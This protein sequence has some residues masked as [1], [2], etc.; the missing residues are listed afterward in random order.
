MLGIRNG[1]INIFRID[2]WNVNIICLYLQIFHVSHPHLFVV[3]TNIHM[4]ILT[5][6]YLHICQGNIQQYIFVN[7]ADLSIIHYGKQNRPMHCFFIPFN[8]VG[9]MT[10]HWA[11]YLDFMVPRYLVGFFPTHLTHWALDKMT[12]IFQTT[13]SNTFSWMKMYKFRLQ[14]HWCLFPGV[15]LTSF[16]HWFR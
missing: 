14:F 16:H 6:I 8:W 2:Y 15:Q 13:H 3:Y 7:C 9:K 5:E 11:Q 1:N 4:H 12:A 10:S